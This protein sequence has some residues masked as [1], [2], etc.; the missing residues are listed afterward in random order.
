M[1]RAGS[2]TRLARHPPLRRSPAGASSRIGRPAGSRFRRADR[3]VR[4]CRKGS[5]RR[6]LDRRARSSHVHA[7]DSRFSTLR[8]SEAADRG[9]PA[10]ETPCIGA[11][12]WALPAVL[13]PDGS[14]SSVPSSAPHWRTGGSLYSRFLPPCTFA[15]VP[16]SDLRPDY[17]FGFL[18]RDWAF[19]KWDCVPPG[20]MSKHRASRSRSAMMVPMTGRRS[21]FRS[22]VLGMGGPVEEAEC[23]K[24]FPLLRRVFPVTFHTANPC[25]CKGPV[26]PYPGS[27]TNDRTR[28]PI[29]PAA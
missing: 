14:V 13:G 25:G 28:T 4:D 10:W 22:D 21:V 7:T 5:R 9:P 26:R 17:P 27:P 16:G 20:I 24:G 3:N 18:I 15:I 8:P 11:E 19:Q 29:D 1:R 23:R 6:V 12:E 2:E